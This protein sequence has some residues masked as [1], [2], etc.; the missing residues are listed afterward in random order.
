MVKLAKWVNL[1]NAP[2]RFKIG[3][4]GVPW[5]GCDSEPGGI[6]EAPNTPGYARHCEAA[7]YTR[8]TPDMQ[9]SID[10]DAQLKAMIAE[11]ELRNLP[12]VPATEE[13][14][15]EAVEPEPTRPPEEEP[16]ST[17]PEQPAKGNLIRGR[18]NR[19]PKG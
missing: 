5:P 17:E 1:T 14:F 9:R 8:L 3:V 13:H 16:V 11:E 15:T 12:K 4:S 7:G 19:S 2:I 18:S 6:V 10:E